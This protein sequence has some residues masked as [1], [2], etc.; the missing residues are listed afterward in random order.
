MDECKIEV[1]KQSTILKIII[2]FQL[3]PPFVEYLI[4][5][6]EERFGD[7]PT[8]VVQGFSIIP[9]IFVNQA[10]RKPDVIESANC[11]ANDL[12]RSNS[13][14]PELLLW[15]TFWRNGYQGN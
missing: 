11:Y 3:Q 9:S 8:T 5:E 2:A 13:I 7:A 15:E 4:A 1:I 12:P 10:D 6:M 14:L